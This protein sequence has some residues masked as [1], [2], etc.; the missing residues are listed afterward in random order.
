MILGCLRDLSVRL[1]RSAKRRCP[2][3]HRPEAQLHDHNFS[4]RCEGKADLP[5]GHQT[6]CCALLGRL[7]SLA[8]PSVIIVA[9]QQTSKLKPINVRLRFVSA[10]VSFVAIHPSASSPFIAPTEFR[11]RSNWQG[12]EQGKL[13]IRGP[14]IICK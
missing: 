1:L 10:P 7:G 9:P 13:L 5:R 8:V 11:M 6:C 12:A 2:H 4:A 14:Q 3:R